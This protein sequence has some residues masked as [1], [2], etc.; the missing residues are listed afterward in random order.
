MPHARSSGSADASLNVRPHTQPVAHGGDAERQAS[1]RKP[2]FH[3]PLTGPAG[4][5]CHTDNETDGRTLRAQDTLCGGEKAHKMVKAKAEYA[6]LERRV[7]EA[8]GVAR[9]SLSPATAD[10]HQLL[11]AVELLLD[12]TRPRASRGGKWRLLNRRERL[13]KKYLTTPPD[14]RRARKR[15]GLDY[16]AAL[17]EAV[18]NGPDSLRYRRIDPAGHLARRPDPMAYPRDATSH[19]VRTVSGGLPSLGKRR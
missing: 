19:S 18:S 13:L 14:A 3:N 6:A 16:A 10:R 12:Q 9:S 15:A 1:D 5:I 8:Q 7:S 4:Q 17:K 2:G 11:S